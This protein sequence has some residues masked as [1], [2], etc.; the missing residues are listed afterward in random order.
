MD[1]KDFGAIPASDLLI[2]AANPLSPDH[3]IARHALDE[4]VR[5]PAGI[6]LAWLPL[7]GFLR[8]ST[9]AR[10]MPNPLSVADALADDPMGGQQLSNLAYWRMIARL[11]PV[12][13]RLIVAGGGGYNPWAVARCWAGIWAVNS[14]R[15]S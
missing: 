1:I 8:V 7:V 10:V 13:P 6:G 3:P 9:M 12:S 14:C 5:E 2:H 11:Q 15:C 4:A